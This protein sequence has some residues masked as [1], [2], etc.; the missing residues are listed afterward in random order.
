MIAS[1]A[2]MLKIR[3]PFQSLAVRLSDYL[4]LQVTSRF[5]FFGF[6][7][8]SEGHSRFC[9]TKICFRR[10]TFSLIRSSTST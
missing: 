3:F 5:S 1:S 7:T 8:L 6:G 9:I 4:A 2:E 10:E